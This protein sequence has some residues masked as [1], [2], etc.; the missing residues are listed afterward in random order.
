MTPPVRWFFALLLALGAG[1]GAYLAGRAWLAPE[2][3]PLPRG[4]PPLRLR[5]P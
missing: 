4:P 2:P 1:A 5:R 3:G